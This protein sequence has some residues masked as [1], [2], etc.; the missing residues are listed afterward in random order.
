MPRKTKSYSELVKENRDHLLNDK[1]EI[2]RIFAAIDR[3]VS[4]E[5]IVKRKSKS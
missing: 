2:E 1:D 4:V 3:K 5:Q